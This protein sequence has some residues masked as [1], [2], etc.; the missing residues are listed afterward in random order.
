MSRRTRPTIAAP[1][2]S[3]SGPRT[4]ARSSSRRRSRRCNVANSAISKIENA[5]KYLVKS[6]ALR[7]ECQLTATQAAHSRNPDVQ[8]LALLSLVLAEI[9]GQQNELWCLEVKAA[10]EVRRG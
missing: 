4:R 10:L 2:R 8:A 3:I 6:R 9:T 7:K 5:G 1:K